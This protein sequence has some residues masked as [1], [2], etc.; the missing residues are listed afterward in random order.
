MPHPRREVCGRRRA[1][2]GAWFAQRARRSPAQHASGGRS[3][4]GRTRLSA[5]RESR[6]GAPRALQQP[7]RDA[8]DA[9]VVAAALE[10]L[11]GPRLR[12]RW[13][14]AGVARSRVRHRERHAARRARRP[15][16]AAERWAAAA[17]PLARSRFCGQ[18]GG[19]ALDRQRGCRAD[20]Q[21][22]VR[23]LLG[24]KAVE[25]RPV[26]PHRV[27]RQRAVRARRRP[28]ERPLPR[29]SRD[30]E[31]LRR[32]RAAAKRGCAPVAAVLRRRHLGDDATLRAGRAARRGRSAA[33]ALRREPLRVGG[34][35][36][37]ADGG[38]GRGGRRVA[39]RLV[40]PDSEVVACL[41]RE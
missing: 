4:S 35:G 3:P 30:Q 40:A 7:A 41:N 20:R 15:G 28:G 1:S 11:P 17:A 10:R 5:R 27:C 24:R 13:R 23:E 18:G 6:G 38:A 26:G 2:V 21:P 14:D 8:G 34:G 36:G 33:L 12:P 25:V 22:Q 19:P 39:A 37:A 31:R 32:R 16:G 9:A 29:P